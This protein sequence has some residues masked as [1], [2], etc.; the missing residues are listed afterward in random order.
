[1]QMLASENSIMEGRISLLQF[2]YVCIVCHGFCPTVMP[3]AI[4]VCCGFLPHYH[5][6]LFTSKKIIINVHGV[7]IHLS[8]IFEEFSGQLRFSF[9]YILN[10]V[11]PIFGFCLNRRWCEYLQM[12]CVLCL[13]FSL[14]Y[15]QWICM[16]FFYLLLLIRLNFSYFF[17][18]FWCV[19]EFGVFVID[20]CPKSYNFFIQC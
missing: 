12:I 10:N 2:L 13:Q 14:N 6:Q 19:C 1:M 9:V 16:P 3:S 11:H 15:H 17:Q 5:R 18:C 4:Y 20:K 8:M 7:V